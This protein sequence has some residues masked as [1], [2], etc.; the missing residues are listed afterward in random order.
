TGEFQISLG[1]VSRASDPNTSYLHEQL[2]VVPVKNGVSALRLNYQHA[3]EIKAEIPEEPPPIKGLSPRLLISEILRTQEVKQKVNLRIRL[4]V[5]D[6]EM[7]QTPTELQLRGP[8][9]SLVATAEPSERPDLASTLKNPSLLMS[10]FDFEIPLRGLPERVSELTVHAVHKTATSPLGVITVELSPSKGLSVETR[11]ELGIWNT[12]QFSVWYDTDATNLSPLRPEVSTPAGLSGLALRSLLFFISLASTALVLLSFVVFGQEMWRG[13]SQA[14][15]TLMILYA[16]TRWLWNVSLPKFGGAPIL[17]MLVATPLAI[18]LVRSRQGWL[19][20]LAIAG[21]AG[22]STITDLTARFS[23]IP[24]DAWWGRMIFFSRY[25]DWFVTQGYA[26]QILME[27][28]L[29]GGEGVFYFQPGVRYLV[30]LAKLVL[31][32]ND[33][34]ISILL[35]SA[36]LSL[37]LLLGRFLQRRFATRVSCAILGAT[38]FLMS[39][40]WLSG[41]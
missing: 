30:F 40:L 32:E 24:N 2:V 19:G 41:S 39:F 38:I 36:L 31:G 37:S 13:L 5:V 18:W 29:R 17:W 23:S 28:S 11:A 10:G 8:D 26:R 25:D 12:P 9:G 14:A 7:R 22:V 33:V 27:G 20:L 34:L 35:L 21:S 3:D 4:A 6:R 1:A 15:L 16:A